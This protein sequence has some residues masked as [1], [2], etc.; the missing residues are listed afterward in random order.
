MKANELM[1]GLKYIPQ[2]ENLYSI[3]RSGNVFSHISG[4]FLKRLHYENKEIQTKL[5]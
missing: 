4:K 3:D 1:I 5:F 2:Y